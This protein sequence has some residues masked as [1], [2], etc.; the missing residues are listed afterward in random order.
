MSLL[1]SIMPS[2]M[3]KIRVMVMEEQVEDLKRDL[4]WANHTIERQRF[5]LKTLEDVRETTFTETQQ[6]LN[7][8]LAWFRA[9]VN[10]TGKV[11]F[12]ERRLQNAIKRYGEAT[13]RKK[14][15]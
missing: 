6:V 15:D 12:H 11:R 8:A 13:K 14:A 2:R 1:H 10:V 3:N 9:K 5:D 4:A 7:N